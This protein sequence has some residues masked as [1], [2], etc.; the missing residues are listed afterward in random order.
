MPST[1]RE[2]R[3]TRQPPRRPAAAP[4]IWLASRS[5]TTRQMGRV[6]FAARRLR[7]HRAPP[8]PGQRQTTGEGANPWRQPPHWR[9]R[10]RQRHGLTDRLSTALTLSR[11]R[12][13][14]LQPQPVVRPANLQPAPPGFC[15][16]P[17]L[18]PSW[19]NQTE[20]RWGGRRTQPDMNFTPFIAATNETQPRR[21]RH[22][23]TYPHQPPTL[24]NA[25]DR[26]GHRTPVNLSFSSGP[27]IALG[28]DGVRILL[29]PPASLPS[30]AQSTAQHHHCRHLRPHGHA[31]P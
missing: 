4:A 25:H 23:T 8:Q 10:A 28:G 12:P 6:P 21:L 5:P 19:P 17:R 11:H 16:R 7:P 9:Q 26:P 31:A 13:V 20:S 3:R 22:R 18:P 30:S 29:T 2:I 15:P 24:G 1:R 27:S 14:R